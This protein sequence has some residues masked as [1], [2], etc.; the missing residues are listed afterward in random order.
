MKYEFDHGDIV[1]F[2]SL[3]TTMHK[4][5]KTEEEREGQ[6]GMARSCATGMSYCRSESREWCTERDWAEVALRLA[7]LTHHE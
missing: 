4:K 6:L 2:F 7:G 5:F 3:L 1:H